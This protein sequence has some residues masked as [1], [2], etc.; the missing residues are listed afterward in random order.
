M[1]SASRLLC[2]GKGHDKPSS[3]PDGVLV[4]SVNAEEGLFT[5]ASLCFLSQYTDLQD[6]YNLVLVIF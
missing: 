6:I 4:Q 1:N 3:R 2:G 5:D